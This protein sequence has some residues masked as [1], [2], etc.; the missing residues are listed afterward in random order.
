MY[1]EVYLLDVPYHLDRPFGYLS[2]DEVECGSLV[3]VPFGRNNSLRTGVVTDV[4]D[5][6]ADNSVEYKSI[7]SVLNGLFKLTPELLALAGGEG[8]A[9]GTGGM[10]TK[11]NAAKICMDVGCDMIIMNG[12]NP[13]QLYSVFEGTSV[14][15]RFAANKKENP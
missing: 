9:L 14:G 11:L 8:S 10:R 13:T 2:G 4:S 7:H 5:A 15:T 6:P 1:L 12:A 3:R